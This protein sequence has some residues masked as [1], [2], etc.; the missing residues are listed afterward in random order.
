MAPDD[1]I[2]KIDLL[3]KLIIDIDSAVLEYSDT[4][5]SVEE[6]CDA[7][8]QLNLAKRDVSVAYDSLATYVAHLMDEAKK[9]DMSL[10]GGAQIERKVAYDRKGW[11]HKD[12]ALDVAHRLSQ[13]VVDMDT[14]EVVMSQE[15]LVVKLLDYVQPSYWRVGELGKIGINADNYCETGEPKVSLIVR[16]GENQ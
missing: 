2:N 14:G 10:N 1:L 4:N 16:K 8:L 12:L 11:R 13:S 6:S 15:E 5:P 7:L 9:K 3:R